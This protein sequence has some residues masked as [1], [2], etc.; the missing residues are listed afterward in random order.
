M[1]KI[2]RDGLEIILLHS[3][4]EDVLSEREADTLCPGIHE[5]FP[6][7]LVRRYPER[8]SRDDAKY[9][10]TALKRLCDSSYGVFQM[11][12]QFANETL[13]ENGG[14]PYIRYEHLLRWRSTTHLV[15]AAPF[16]MAFLAEQDSRREANRSSFVFPPVLTTNNRRLKAVLDKGLAEN[17]FHLNGS[18][19]SFLL[20]WIFLMNNVT[21]NKGVFNKLRRHKLSTRLNFEDLYTLV[22][23]AAAIRMFLFEQLHGI[24]KNKGK[25]VLPKSSE[26]CQDQSSA[27]QREL[28]SLRSL[29][30]SFVQPNFRP[31]YAI[32]ETNSSA[33]LLFAG[34]NRFLY[35]MFRAI[36]TKNK[37]ICPFN[38]LFLAYLMTASQ[39]RSEMIQSNDSFGFDNFSEYQGRK[40]WFYERYPIWNNQL[41]RVAAQTTLEDNRLQTFEARII[42]RQTS[43]KLAAQLENLNLSINDKEHPAEDDKK[44]PPTPMFYVLHFPKSIDRMSKDK[45]S[46]L[47]QC[48]HSTLRYSIQQRTNAII[49]LRESQSEVSACVL[50]IDACSAEIG[51]RPE[52]FTPAFRRLSHHQ[53]P[54]LFL[55]ERTPENL[56]VTYHVGEDFLDVADGLRAIDEAIT[57]LDLIQG[58]RIGHALALGIDADEWYNRKSFRIILPRQDLLDN[59]VWM[60]CKLSKAGQLNPVLAAQLMREF[61]SQVNYIYRQNLPAPE[62][63]HYIDIESYWDAWH[64]RG[65]E[66][67]CYKYYQNNEVFVRQLDMQN[68]ELQML[69]NDNKNQYLHEIRR[70]NLQAIRLFH[71]YHYNIK[72]KSCGS[73]IIEKEV[74]A[75]YRQG[76]ELLQQLM[77][78]KISRRNIG[79]ETNPSSNVLIS[80]FNRYDKHPI[81]V[82]NDKGLQNT[83]DNQHLLVS[84]NT[85]DQ[86]VFDTSLENEYALMARGLEQMCDKNGQTMFLPSDVYSWLDMVRQMGIEQSFY[87]IKSND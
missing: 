6:D 62:S 80:N 39:F 36:I 7:L 12:F 10:F 46:A 23:R 30:G 25:P 82:F 4:V 86:G 2:L 40:S 55:Q 51:C 14:K 78:R 81:V 34:E 76:V 53:A 52:V 37:S 22:W 65:D 59:C 5:S 47:F 20:S 85:D 58:S 35:D 13:L 57:F 61:S 41:S 54:Q 72:V 75:E 28:D 16:V 71:H 31:D 38:N 1:D 8:Y 19:P 42:P 56:Q 67:E 17:H 45:M 27:L 84:I 79:I 60:Y 87:S 26:E 63:D 21:G 18:T 24:Q 43:A 50:G 48:R 83:P 68:T 33:W 49:K 3:S 44:A 29:C 74:T 73:E 77:R 15:G 11:L 70:H 66:P 64:L 32:G 69:L 9:A